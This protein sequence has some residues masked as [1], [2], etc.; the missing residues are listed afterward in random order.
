MFEQAVTT[1]KIIRVGHLSPQD[2]DK[3]I[4]Y[5]GGE[6]AYPCMIIDNYPLPPRDAMLKGLQKLRNVEI[7][8]KVFPD[9][10]TRDVTAMVNAMKGKPVNVVIGIGG[11][12]SMD[13][14]KG[15]AVILS[16]GGEPDDYLG[17]MPS[18]KIEKRDVKLI[19]IPTTAGTG[20]EVTKVGVYTSHDGRKYTLG[21]PLMQAD[22]A[23]LVTEYVETLPPALTAS[24]AFDALSH[25]LETIWNKNAN[26]LTDRVAVESAVHI[27]KWMERAYD[28]SLS[29]STDG[30]AEMLEG[31]CMAGAA[32]SMT[33]TA[34][35]HALSFIL[36]EE[37][38][39]PHGT[40]CAFLLEDVFRL[41]VVNV[42]TK[43]RLAKI[44][45]E[46]FGESDAGMTAASGEHNDDRMTAAVSGE[47]NDDRMTAAASGER[48]DDCMTAALLDRIVALK[49]KFSLPFTFG[50]LNICLEVG[51]IGDLFR[52]SLDD[53]KMKNNIVD[54]DEAMIVSL[55]TLK[56]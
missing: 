32:F 4:F 46:L 17:A 35:V 29:G 3:L 53:P 31:A 25:A 23:V 22:I 18:R 44:G 52:K 49:K 11:G 42:A 48:D 38:H 7:Q 15:V 5:V 36:S 13:A 21:H 6:S 9:P 30:R 2:M 39:V 34:A 37:W 1:T 16:N 50:D 19:L 28:S 40:A 27:L 8:D 41:N 26:P 51:R 56:I 55:L 20:S 24:T 43:R 12:S 45:R 14:A 54:M 47:H 10:K 33:G